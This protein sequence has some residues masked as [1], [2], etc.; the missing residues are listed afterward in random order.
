MRIHLKENSD[1]NRVREDVSKRKIQ[2]WASWRDHKSWVCVSCLAQ[3]VWK[4]DLLIFAREDEHSSSANLKLRV[5]DQIFKNNNRLISVHLYK[6]DVVKYFKA[7]F[8]QSQNW[9]CFVIVWMSL[10]IS[11]VWWTNYRRMSFLRVVRKIWESKDICDHI[12]ALTILID[13][14]LDSADFSYQST[15]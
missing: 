3:Y 13:F 2:E 12:L 10:W 9:H 14:L 5:S 7:I 1:E 8:N 11:R 15:K 4:L 6:N